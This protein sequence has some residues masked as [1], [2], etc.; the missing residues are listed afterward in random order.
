MPSSGVLPPD[1]TPSAL[2]APSTPLGSFAA[3]AVSWTAWTTLMGFVGL[4]ALAVL[5]AGPAARRI[6]PEALGA[7][8][9]RLSRA[10][11][12]VGVLAVP[13]VLSDL[14]QSASDNGGYDYSAAW[15]SLYDGTNAG[16]LSG[17]E[18]AFILI[19]VALIAPLAVRRV[20]AGRVGRWLLPSALGAGAIALG[21]TKFPDAVPTDW[22]RTSFETLMWMLH[23][24][25]GGV[26]IGG[27]LGLALL[28]LP[29]AVARQD[30]AAFWSGTIRRFSAAA[31]S[32][33]AAIALSGLF[34]YWEHVDGPSQ[35][36]TTMYGRVLGVKILLFGTMLLLGTFN[37]FWLHPR[38]D[39]LRSAG[40]ERPLRAILLKQFPAVVGAEAVLGLAV[41]FVAPFLHG[42]A[43]NQAYQAGL[44]AH[45]ATAANGK[46]PKLAAKVPDAATWMWGSAETIAVIALMIIGY[47]VSGRIARRRAAALAAS[48]PLGAEFEEQAAA[49]EH[50]GRLI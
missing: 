8:T 4:T 9:A 5:A 11:L 32:C 49:V 15:D 6:G 17:L 45:A 34:L 23:L 39:A 37:Q 44:A 48:A 42:S 21:T 29:G 35:L 38:I 33:V 2:A 46:L 13:A 43:R 3:S 18:V 25:G 40:D 36:F 47:R 31:M 14:A 20:A 22:G 50:A 27:L 28:A 41:L 1:L 10:A 12:V 19:G 26:W 16:R 30:S 7:V 24:L